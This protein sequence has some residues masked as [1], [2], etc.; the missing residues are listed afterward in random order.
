VARGKD[1]LAAGSALDL[2]LIL[3]GQALVGFARGAALRLLRESPLHLLPKKEIIEVHR[4]SPDYWGDP[5]YASA[6]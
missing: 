2:K 3:S 4:G 6:T 1:D 5:R